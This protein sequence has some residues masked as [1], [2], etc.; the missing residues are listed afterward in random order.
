M[1]KQLDI[2]KKLP[3]DLQQNTQ[4]G[5]FLSVIAVLS[6]LFL[7]LSELSFYLQMEETSD[8]FVDS[9]KGG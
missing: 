7:F 2:F 1:I 9:E 3:S 8:M 6:M 4:C 5:A